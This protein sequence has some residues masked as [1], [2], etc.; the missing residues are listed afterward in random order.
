[1]RRNTDTSCFWPARRQVERCAGVEPG[2]LPPHAAAAACRLQE[3]Q[4]R[5]AAGAEDRA[6]AGRKAGRQEGRPLH[7]EARTDAERAVLSLCRAASWRAR[8]S[9]GQGGAWQSAVGSRCGAREPGPAV[10]LPQRGCQ[11]CHQPPPLPPPCWRS[12]RSQAGFQLLGRGGE[13]R[14]HGQGSKGLWVRVGL[15]WEHAGHALQAVASSGI[16]GQITVRCCSQASPG[17][18][19]LPPCTTHTHLGSKMTTWNQV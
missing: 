8:A 11:P 6:G 12:R 15:H 10:P 17:V 19:G 13:R 5:P 1:M 4:Q 14:A 2:Q 7:A 9:R 18:P 16:A 3:Q